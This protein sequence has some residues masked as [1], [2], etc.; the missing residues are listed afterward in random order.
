M[1]G[2]Q[3]FLSY[4]RDDEESVSHLYDHLAAAGLRPWM[5]K[6]DL[7][8]GDEWDDSIRNAIRSSQYFL[9]I[10]TPRSLD[11]RGYLQKEIKHALD[12]QDEKIPGDRYVIPVRLERCEIPS[13]LNRFHSADLF[14]K[15]GLSRLIVVLKGGTPVGLYGKEEQGPNPIARSMTLSVGGIDM[16]CFFPSISS[17]SKNSLTPLDLLRILV[18][19]KH[20]L[21]L[22]S[23]FDVHNADRNS[24]LKMVSLLQTAMD[25]AQVVLLDSGLFEKK[26]LRTNWSKKDFHSALKVTPCHLS[27]CFD[28]PN[29]KGDPE[30]VALAILAALSRDQKAAD[31]SAI[32][33]I[34]HAQRPEDFPDLCKGLVSRIRPTLIGIPE[35]ELGVGI[36]SSAATLVRIRMALDSTGQYYP[37]H[38]LGTGNPLSILIFAACGADS[39]DGLEWCQTAVDN[40]S[41]Q[42]YHHGQLDFFSHQT[43]F[44]SDLTMSY[45]ARLLAHNLDF[46]G[47]WMAM[48]QAKL[49]KGEIREMVNKYLPEGVSDKINALLKE[50]Q[51]ANICQTF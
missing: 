7:K 25:N 12:I 1:P 29:S 45:S 6:R 35:R 15:D 27:F 18:S 39:F 31:F 38:L 22:I 46:Y 28:N 32:I 9:V 20:P 21:F 49:I 30:E 5:D 4:A 43:A 3:V 16:P 8:P 14:E 34:I 17:A 19:V 23:A 50:N 40:D 26:W 42:L 24:R 37:I 44:G 48:I 47:K 2:L 10:L 11:K 13:R 36:F 33:P 51:I 41:G